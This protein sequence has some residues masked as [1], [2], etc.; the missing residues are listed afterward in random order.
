M[1][2]RPS[3]LNDDV[4]NALATEIEDGMPFKYACD[5]CEITHKLFDEWL[6]QG[7][8]DAE[9][10]AD[11]IYAKFFLS[12]KKA[13]GRFVKDSKRRIRNGESGW[14]GTAWWLERTNKEFQMN[15]ENTQVTEN[16]IVNTKMK[17]LRK[18]KDSK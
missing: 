9:D 15:T 4:I 3:K 16:I 14:Q 8:A 12:I 2:T 13:Y 7:Q 17:S 6:K 18:D 5:L 11:T 10:Q 1:L